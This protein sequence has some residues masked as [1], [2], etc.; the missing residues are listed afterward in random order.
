MKRRATHGG[1][2]C[3]LTCGAHHRSFTLFFPLLCKPWKQQHEKNSMDADCVHVC[4][5]AGA[6][7]GAFA[8][9]MVQGNGD[10]KKTQGVP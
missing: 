10:T 2:S 1:T 7:A 6:A 5:C 4:V 9:M 3:Q 8:S